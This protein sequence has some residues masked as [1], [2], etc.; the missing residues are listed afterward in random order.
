MLRAAASDSPSRAAI[1][2]RPDGY[3]AHV[4]D[5]LGDPTLRFLLKRSA[6]Q[7]NDETQLTLR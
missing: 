6:V 4:C 5:D 2:I 3:V 1:L 7:V